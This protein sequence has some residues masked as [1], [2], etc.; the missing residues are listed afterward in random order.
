[1]NRNAHQVHTLKEA[2]R[3]S[4][5]IDSKAIAARDRRAMLGIAHTFEQAAAA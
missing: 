4:C 1:V 5:L 3:M 2:A